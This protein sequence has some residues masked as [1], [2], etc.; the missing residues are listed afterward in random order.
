MSITNPEEFNETWDWD[1]LKGCFGS[2]KISPTDIDGCVERKGRKLYLETKKP[3]VQVPVGQ[4]ITF[5]DLA[6]EGHTVLYIWGEINNPVEIKRLSNRAEVNYTPATLDT[7]RAIVSAWF[8]F[9][10]SHPLNFDKPEDIARDLLR[11]KGPQ[12]CKAMVDAWG[13]LSE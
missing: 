2:T 12:F 13:A 4:D 9:A 5:R 10:E 1:I 11:R 3:G 7:L 6:K 8:L